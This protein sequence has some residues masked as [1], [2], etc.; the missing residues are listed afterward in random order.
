MGLTVREALL[1]ADFEQ[2]ANALDPA[3][4][5]VGL[6][7]GE[8][9]RSREEVLDTFRGALEAGV[10]AKVEIVDEVEGMLVVDPHVE[11]PA[12]RSPHLHQVFVV[13]E[14]RIVEL[15]DYPDRS[16]ALKAVRG[17]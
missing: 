2:V 15:R 7:P 6:F 13:R 1:A 17:A 4:V 14:G 5:W 12:E 9:C 3:V 16:S 11:P 8:L 10:R